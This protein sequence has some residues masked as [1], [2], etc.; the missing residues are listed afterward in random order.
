MLILQ[1]RDHFLDLLGL[2]V[3]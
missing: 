2:L 1:S 3:V